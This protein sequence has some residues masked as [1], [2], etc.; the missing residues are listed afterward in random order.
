M[1]EN[2]VLI[3]GAAGRIGSNLREFWGDRY[4]LRLADINPIKEMVMKTDKE[5]IIDVIKATCNKDHRVGMVHTHDD[6]VFIRPTGNPLNMEGWNA[7]M[8]NENVRVD[9]KAFV[10]HRA[11]ARVGG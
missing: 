9:S 3:T 6:C 1:S 4:R 11:N 2:V 10:V 8:T 5:Q 7:M